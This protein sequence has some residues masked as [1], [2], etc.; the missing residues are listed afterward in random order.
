ML[1]ESNKSLMDLWMKIGL[2]EKDKTDRI[3]NLIQYHQDLQQQMLDEE[4]AL[5][6]RIL[7]IVKELKFEYVSVCQQLNLSQ[8]L[9]VSTIENLGL[10]QQE[11]HL[12][13]KVESLHQM[14]FERLDK[15]CALLK[16]EHELCKCLNMPPIVNGTARTGDEDVDEANVPSEVQLNEIQQHIIMLRDEKASVPLFCEIIFDK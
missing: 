7:T 10:L 4:K 14:K 6:A 8:D 9:D 1:T 15:L 5:H 3:K 16:E 2:T 13:G 11:F 12:K